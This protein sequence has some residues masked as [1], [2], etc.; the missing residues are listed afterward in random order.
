MTRFAWD[1]V[2][3]SHSEAMPFQESVTSTQRCPTERSPITLRLTRCFMN[4][5]AVLKLSSSALTHGASFNRTEASIP[6]WNRISSE[7]WSG[8]GLVELDV[9]TEQ[10]PHAAADDDRAAKA[11]ADMPPHFD[12]AWLSIH[13]F[14]QSCVTLCDYVFGSSWRIFG[15]PPRR[16]SC[17]AGRICPR[18]SHNIVFGRINP[19]AARLAE[20]HRSGTAGTL[21]V[22]STTA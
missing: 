10:R 7:V 22:S 2:R 13:T 19:L 21:F 6:N 1:R 15:G 12:M 3:P 5:V 17:W 16:C 20:P 11:K 9:T 8:S 18:K 14:Q 4:W